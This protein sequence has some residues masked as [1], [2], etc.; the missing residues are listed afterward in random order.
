MNILSSTLDHLDIS[1]LVFCYTSSC[2]YANFRANLHTDHF[3]RW[4]YGMNEV[5]KTPA[6]AATHIENAIALL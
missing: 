6:R 1:P 3:T 4:A 5:R 2:V